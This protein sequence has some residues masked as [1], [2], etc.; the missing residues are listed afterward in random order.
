MGSV[1]KKIIAGFLALFLA[2]SAIIVLLLAR[3]YQFNNKYESILQNVLNLN[4]IKGVGAK[5]AADI[6]NACIMGADVEESGMLSNI[7]K[8]FTYLDE[9]EESIGDS[10]KYQGNRSMV[11]SL[12]QAMTKYKDSMEAI[13]ALG[14]GTSF[15]GFNEEVNKLASSFKEIGNEM[16]SYCNNNITMELERSAEIQ[17]DIEADFR[18]TILLA[19]AAFAAVLLV[20]TGICA[21]IVRSI[22]KPINMLKKEITIVAGGDLTKEEIKFSSRSE[23]SSLADAF[24]IMSSNLKE[25]IGTVIAVTS[26]IADT[27]VV[28]ENT[29]RSNTK[30]C[31]EITSSAEDI[32]RRIHEQSDEIEIIMN[33]M[34]DMKKISLQI[35]EDI[36]GIDL[37]TLGSK[38]KAEEGNRSIA[39]FVEQLAQVNQTVSQIAGAAEAF[40]SNTQEVNKILG[41]ISDISQQTK[42]LSLNASIEA[43][44]AGEAGR[45]FSVVAEEI[46]T[47]AEKTVGL[48]AAISKIVDGLQNS[49]KDMTAKMELGLSQLEQGNAMVA[50]TQDKFRDILKD[51]GQTNDEIRNVHEMAGSL[52]QSTADISDSMVDVNNIIEENTKMTER[53]VTITENQT[54]NQKQLEDKVQTLDELVSG[55]KATA[56]KFKVNAEAAKEEVS[57]SSASGIALE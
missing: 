53:I 51:A 17:K 3:T 43:A 52:S 38:N 39:A 28:A 55:L 8:M 23:F 21:W 18:N 26:D 1:A 30:D 11:N 57:A 4:T 12:R 47:L 6:T 35:V 14:D 34:Q 44:R 42:L 13:I 32:N 29:S 48:V 45:G 24:N 22:V 15:P 27:A 19:I 36:E 25:I 2:F 33:Q 40:G 31:M 10:E 41:G 56:S 7:E 20:S 9:L 16:S 54:E 37:R 5:A 50:E 46:N 49:M